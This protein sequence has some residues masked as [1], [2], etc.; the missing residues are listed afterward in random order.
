MD[1]IK[2]DFDL[3]SIKINMIPDPFYRGLVIN[4]YV[5][6]IINESTF[7]NPLGD[8]VELPVKL[9]IWLGADWLEPLR[10][11]ILKKVNA[12]IYRYIDPVNYDK[13]TNKGTALRINI[14]DWYTLPDADKVEQIYNTVI[15]QITDGKYQTI[16]DEIKPFIDITREVIEKK[17]DIFHKSQP[18]PSK[19]APDIIVEAMQISGLPRGFYT[20][21]P[22][23]KQGASQ[24]TAEGASQPTAE[25]G[26]V[27]ADILAD[28]PITETTEPAPQPEL[29]P[30]QVSELPVKLLGDVSNYANYI[31]NYFA[32]FVGKKYAS[33]REKGGTIPPD[34]ALI[35]F[36]PRA[37][38]QANGVTF[39]GTTEKLLTEAVDELYN[40][41]LQFVTFE[42]ERRGKRIHRIYKTRFIQGIEYE[43]ET[44]KHGITTKRIA[45][46]RIDPFFLRSPELPM[47][48]TNKLF[49]GV[50]YRGALSAGDIGT[51]ATWIL[52]QYD[53]GVNIPWSAVFDNWQFIEKRKYRVK[54]RIKEN[55]TARGFRV[56]DS[57]TKYFV[58]LK[59]NTKG[60]EV[61]DKKDTKKRGRPR[62]DAKK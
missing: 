46:I 43:T 60:G 38:A 25:G 9:C 31:V 19:P 58:I 59:P 21:T 35:E 23:N 12:V 1:Y 22:L 4:A 56:E 39:G 47:I 8:W 53:K 50:E 24:P 49:N 20:P 6:K 48:S 5:H 57:G 37:I 14:D 30:V 15:T 2:I 33:M 13:L 18:A 27:W 42:G 54:D 62:K 29:T 45:A 7:I 40:T 11:E 44:D 61:S 41:S 16:T 28:A 36:N 32:G 26:D 52:N 51:A 34:E 10:D 55:I 3:T 17:L